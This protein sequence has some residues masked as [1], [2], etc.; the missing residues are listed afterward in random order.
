MKGLMVSLYAMTA[1]FRD[2][3]THLYQ[4]TILAPPPTTIVG[5]AGAAMGLKYEDILNYFKINKISVGCTIKYNGTGKDL[6]NYSKISGAKVKKDILIREF[7]NDVNVDIFFACEDLSIIQYLNE[8]FKNPCFALTLGN[9]DDIAMISDVKLC[10]RVDTIESRSIKNTWIH[11]NYIDNFELDWEKVKAMPIK[12]TIKHPVIKN[13][14]TDFKF[15][16]NDE[17]EA[18]RFDKFT[19]LGDMH[20]LKNAITVYTFYDKAISLFSFKE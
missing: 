8:A 13:L 18:T 7:L 19:F 5:L 12:H 1:S 10:D 3:N 4:E 6:W 15:N 2:P 9:S 11:G 17:R 20:I 14:P 16:E